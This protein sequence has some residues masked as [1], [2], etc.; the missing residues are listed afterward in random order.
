MKCA[1]ADS[2]SFALLELIMVCG[3]VHAGNDNT[4]ADFKPVCSGSSVTE[5]SEAE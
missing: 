4:N 3:C 1:V 2:Q 5:C